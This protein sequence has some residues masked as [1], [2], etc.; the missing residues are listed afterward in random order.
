MPSDLPP[1]RA[2]IDRISD[3]VC[4]LLVGPAGD[5]HEVAHTSLPPGATEGSVVKIDFDPDLTVGSVDN[6]LTRA[7]S[8]EATRRLDRIRHQRDSRHWPQT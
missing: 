7:R 8:D 3:G 5:Q 2:V 4:V 1:D 6:E